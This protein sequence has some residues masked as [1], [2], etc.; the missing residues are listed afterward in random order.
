MKK[1]LSIMALAAILISMN[2]NAQNQKPKEK[3]KKECTAAQM[4]KSKKDK[5]SCSADEMEKCSKEKKPGC[6]S[7][8]K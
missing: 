3:A 6:C 2:G 8:K 4:K 1:I 5:K 7:A